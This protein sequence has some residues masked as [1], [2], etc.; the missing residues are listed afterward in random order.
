LRENTWR[1]VEHGEDSKEKPLHLLISDGPAP[2]EKPWLRGQRGLSFARIEQLENFRR[3]ILSLNRLLRHE[4]GIKPEFGGQTRGESL[5]DPCPEVTEKINRM[6]GDRVNQTAHLI[7]AQALGVRLKYD[8]SQDEDRE[9]ADVHG[10]YECIPRRS[11]VDLIVLEDLSRYTTDKSRS[12][13]E[14]SRL[15]KWCHRAINE[16][17]KLLIEPFGIPVL[18]VFASYSSKFDSRTGAPGFRAT[19]VTAADRFFWQKTIEKQPVARAV[20]DCLDSLA[21]RDYKNLRF[22]L[23]QNGGPIFIPAV[24]GN[25]SLL[26]LRQAD[27]NAAV[28]IGLRAIAGPNCYHAHPRVRLAK[29]KSGANKGKWITRTD[30]KREKAQF[31]KTPAEIVFSD[32][33]A[34][35]DVLKGDNTNLFHDPLKISAYGRANITGVKHPPLAHASALLS[36]QKNVAGKP[37]GAVA[38][39]E[40]EV[41][42]RINIERLKKLGCD[43]SSLTGKKNAESPITNE[44]DNVS[45]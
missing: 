17:V 16:K 18:E 11:P 14:N 31:N 32:L 1:W 33:K 24:K 39:L 10:E 36:R 41:C 44:G 34:D 29:A 43:F 22:V 23:P 37:N 40:W 42:R 12:R 26:P 7:V 20:F 4:V 6:K 28:N 15:M 3:A 27:I 45:M 2:Q 19:E 38:R 25:Q 5:P 9:D 21:T 30:N 35:S 13:S 8:A